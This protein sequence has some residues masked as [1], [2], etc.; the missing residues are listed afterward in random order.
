HRNKIFEIIIPKENEKDL[1]EI[2]PVVKK[3]LTFHPVS[4]MDDVLKYVF[5]DDKAEPK[6]RPKQARSAREKASNA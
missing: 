4:S 6:A 5:V 1:E 2:P 3:K